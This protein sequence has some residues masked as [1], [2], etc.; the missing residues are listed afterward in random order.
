MNKG[1]LNEPISGHSNSSTNRLQAG[2]SDEAHAT[3]QPA[4]QLEDFP[5][6]AP[7]PNTSQAAH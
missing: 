1:N 2:M 3:I 7:E 6:A 5:E 4:A